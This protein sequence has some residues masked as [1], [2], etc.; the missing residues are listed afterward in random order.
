MVVNKGHCMTRALP[1]TFTVGTD[2]GTILRELGEHVHGEYA[3][4][5]SLELVTTGCPKNWVTKLNPYRKSLT[6]RFLCGLLHLNA[7]NDQNRMNNHV[8]AA[9]R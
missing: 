9:H 5:V 4:K 7:L 6:A 3:A 2:T 1:F 8:E